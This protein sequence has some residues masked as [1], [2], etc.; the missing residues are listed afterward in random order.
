MSTANA[1]PY[2]DDFR[3]VLLDHDLITQLLTILSMEST[4]E[5]GEKK[6]GQ[7]GRGGVGAC[8]EETER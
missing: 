8:W 5:K 6:R 2:K 7:L 3:V 4:Y 1:D